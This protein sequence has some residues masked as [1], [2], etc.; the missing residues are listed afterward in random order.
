MEDAFEH[1]RR[2]AADSP[3]LARVAAVLDATAAVIAVKA[4]GDRRISSSP[5]AYFGALL[6]TLESSGASHAQEVRLPCPGPYAVLWAP[7]AR[8][9]SSVC[10]KAFGLSRLPL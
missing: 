9:N 4:G 7:M 2:Q 5:V 3:A 6:T 1:V 8:G 10:I